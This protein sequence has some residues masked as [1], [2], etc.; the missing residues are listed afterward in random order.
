MNAPSVTL[1]ISL[2]PADYRHA[3]ELLPHQVR[4]WRGQASEILITA[5]YQHGAGRFSTNWKEG[6]D[7]IAAL[8]E[9]IPGARFI[10]VDYGAAARARVSE[11]FFGGQPIP[12]KDFR[13]GPFYAYFFA[14][15]AA[16]HDNVFHTDSDI[17]FGGGSRTWMMEALAHMHTHKD[18]LF[19]SPLPGPP[20]ADGGLRSQS[21]EPEPGPQPAFQFHSMTTRLFLLSRRRFRETVKALRSRFP[22]PRE[23]VKALVEGNPPADLPEH[24]FNRAMCRCGLVRRDFLGEHPGM[25]SLHPPYRSEAFYALLPELIRRVESG[26]VPEGQRGCHDVNASMVD[27]S[28]VETALRRNRWWKRPARRG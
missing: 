11:E 26:D 27:W 17:F 6:E 13:G 5:D 20:S 1:Q 21:A 25:W 28:D 22:S 18:V 19:S 4:Q 24:L 3:C 14:L 2:S 7:R 16:A 23:T 10:R 12:A 9:S 8:A 15:N